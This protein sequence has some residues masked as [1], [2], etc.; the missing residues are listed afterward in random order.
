[1]NTLRLMIACAIA[2]LVV[3]ATYL[4]PFISILYCQHDSPFGFCSAAFGPVIRLGG[5][6][7]AYL[8]GVALIEIAVATAVLASAAYF[9]WKAQR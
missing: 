2:L 3:I 5:W 7:T 6:F 4:T 9:V 1:M 8:Y